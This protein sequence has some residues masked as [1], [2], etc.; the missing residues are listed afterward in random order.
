MKLDE[1]QV[2]E[3]VDSIINTK[4]Y[5]HLGLNERTL[6]DIFQQEAL[7]HTSD[8]PLL[9]SVKRKLHNI[10]A[11]YL[12]EPNYTDLAEQLDHIEFKSLESPTLREFC[13]KVMLQHVSTAERIPLLPAFYQQLFKETGKPNTILDLACGLNPLAFPWMGLPTSTQYFAYDILQTRVDFLNKFFRKINMQ[14]LA[15][16]RD[17]LVSPPTQN[18]DLA[19]FFKEAH[20]F[21]KRQPGSN[22]M[23]W[24][25]L[26]ADCIAVSLPTQ[27]ISGKL[28]LLEGHRKLVTNNLPAKKKVDSIQFQN[29]IIFLLKEIDET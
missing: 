7:K 21:E 13:K 6:V 22:R 5:R 2:H 18:A 27:N 23:F 26:N 10:I 11:P 4:K 29:E 15:E 17:I 16:N 9:K 19:F 20:R 1:N 14:P 24:E 3:W 28:N 8:K 12:G 25:K